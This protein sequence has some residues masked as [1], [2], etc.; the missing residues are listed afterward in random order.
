MHFIQ[1][2]RTGGEKDRE[3]TVINAATISQIF[4]FEKNRTRILFCF[5]IRN[6]YAYEDVEESVS[7]IIAMCEYKPD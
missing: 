3:K 7:E 6:D 4:E 2:T 5:E 1:L